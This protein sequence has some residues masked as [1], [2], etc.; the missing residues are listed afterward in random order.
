MAVYISP[1]DYRVR[2]EMATLYWGLGLLACVLL[3][4]TAFTIGIFALIVVGVIVFIKIKQGQLVGGAAIVSET[5]FP[6]I[7]AIAK[8]AAAR[9]CMI[10]PEIYI[11]QDPTLN[12]FATGA[13]GKKS[14]VLHSATVEAMDDKE[15]EYII[16]HE[17]SHIKC[18]HTTLLVLTGASQGISIPPISQI[19]YFVFLSWNRKAEYTCDRGGILANRDPNASIS[20][21]CKIAVGPALFRQMDINGFLN[22]QMV[23]DQ[24][25]VAGFSEKLG[26]HPYLVKRI[27]A[28]LRYFES[29]DYKRLTMSLAD[30]LKMPE[31]LR[32]CG[33]IVEKNEEK[34]QKSKATYLQVSP[35][36]PFP[37]PLVAG[38]AKVRPFDEKTWAMLLHFSQLLVI[39][40]VFF[41]VL[42]K[43]ESPV[44][45]QHGRNAL[46]W[47]ITLL[48]VVLMVLLAG[49]VTC[50]IGFLLMIPLIIPALVFP[51]IA[52]IKAQAGEIWKYPGAIEIVKPESRG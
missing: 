2:G 46:N 39:G 3:F 6:N 44:I 30:E 42:K 13:F 34:D 35:S 47:Q 21:I 24:D 23:L 51:I 7:H 9:L 49:I 1:K 38:H 26:T 50:G 31:D 11:R 16:G 45:D 36:P 19:L 18:G 20:A 17:F 22:Q 5:Q 10:Q 29:D 14:V 48:M 43:D 33:A 41:W 25:H 15:L 27:H 12:A 37:P 52:G 40:P 28:I 32:Q 4:V 8:E